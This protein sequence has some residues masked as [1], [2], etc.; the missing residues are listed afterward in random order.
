MAD[1]Y[2]KHENILIFFLVLI[3]QLSLFLFWDGQ[4][5][6]T[7]SYTH[8]LRAADLLASGVWAETLFMHDNYPFGQMLHFTRIADVFWLVC[9]LPFLVFLPLKQAVFFG[10]LLYQPVMTAACAFALL[11]AMKPYFP[12]LFRLVGVTAFFIQTPVMVIYMPAKPDHHVLI[13]FFCFLTIGCLTHAFVSERKKYFALAG[14]A[15]ALM[16]WTSPEGFLLSFLLIAGMA[17]CVL[18]R[19]ADFKGIFVFV[20]SLFI[21]SGL[22]L[23]INPPYQG[24]FHADNSRLSFLVV[25]IFGFAALAAGIEQKIIEK[26]RLNSAVSRFLFFGGQGIAFFG[27]TLLLF[28]PDAVLSS[29]ISPELWE[30]W[31]KN[32]L[33]LMPAFNNFSDVV[34]FVLPSLVMFLVLALFYKRFSPVQKR[35]AVITGTALVVLAGLA[36]FSS[37]FGRNASVFLPFAFVLAMAVLFE[38]RKVNISASLFSLL[39]YFGCLFYLTAVYAGYYFGA[40][41]LLPGVESRLGQYF[42]PNGGVMAEGNIAPKIAWETGRAVVGSPYHTNEAG[43][44]DMKKFFN[45]SDNDVAV[46]IVKKR[47]IRTVVL[48]NP[49]YLTPLDRQKQVYYH[50]DT[51]LSD[52]LLAGRGIP[53]WLVVPPGMPPDVLQNYLIFTVDFARCP[54]YS[55][56]KPE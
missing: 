25:V 32:I 51:K 20:R 36:F 23:I 56:A 16:V 2:K 33:E 29:P 28:G 12:P 31:G 39:L 13:N 3:P 40:V 4:Y 38:N 22:F 9:S 37:R 19:L 53:C 6:D 49:L 35:L 11:W 30:V 45:T 24:L 15:A 1:Y 47:G 54:G 46:E 42:A 44:L 14:A 8:A 50:R 10:G 27:L 21:W 17:F 52:R 26:G 34:S 55:A 48:R 7:D 43:I 41:E 18:L 5:Q